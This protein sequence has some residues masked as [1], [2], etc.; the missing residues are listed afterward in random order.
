LKADDKSE[1]I[2]ALLKQE[3]LYYEKLKFFL[4]EQKKIIENKTLKNLME[5]IQEKE[6][7]QQNICE[8][9]E[10]ITVELDGL[11]NS[12]RNECISLTNDIREKIESL[13]LSIIS[14][15]NYCQDLM[16]KEK[17]EIHGKISNLRQGKNVIKGY[18]SSFLKNSFISKKL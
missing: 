2:L 1:Q 18:N 13:I 7:Y 4:E 17:V 16:Q 9:D 10:Q 12:K 5:I 8:L 3:F 11:D 14:Q 15:E 6:K